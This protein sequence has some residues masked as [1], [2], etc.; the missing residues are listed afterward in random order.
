MFRTEEDRCPDSALEIVVTEIAETGLDHGETGLVHA[1]ETSG[2]HALEEE[3]GEFYQQF[4]FLD[5]RR[6]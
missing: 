3:L 2:D 6:I 1:E 4:F 5:I